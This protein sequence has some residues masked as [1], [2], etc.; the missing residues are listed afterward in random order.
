MSAQPL[1]AQYFDAADKGR[2]EWFGAGDQPGSPARDAP[3]AYRHGAGTLAATLQRAHAG[4]VLQVSVCGIGLQCNLMAPMG[5]LLADN[6]TSAPIRIALSAPVPALGAFMVADAPFG[7]PFTAVLWGRLAGSGQWLSV[8]QQGETGPA[9]T[10]WGD[11]VAPFVG[12]RASD[13]GRFDAVRFDAVHPTDQ[14]FSPVGISALYFSE[15]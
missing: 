13:G 7:T 5:I 2:L 10:A 6:V 14:P 4:Q 8:Q 11:S 3:G 1:T 12:M 15:A 9:W